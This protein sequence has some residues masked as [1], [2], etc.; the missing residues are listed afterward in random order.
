MLLSKHYHIPKVAME[1]LLP[2]HIPV[3]SSFTFKLIVLSYHLF[4]LGTFW[5]TRLSIEW[6]LGGSVLIIAAFVYLWKSRIELSSIPKELR[7]HNDG[8]WTLVIADDEKCIEMERAIL[9]SPL[10][11]IIAFQDKHKKSYQWVLFADA[12]EKNHYRQLRVWLKN[13]SH[14]VQ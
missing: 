11:T 3:K 7:L 1:Q 13:R 2:E 12:I 8:Q 6:Q 14:S 5:F 9:I 4:L 10:L